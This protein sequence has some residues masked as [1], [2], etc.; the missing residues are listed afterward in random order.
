LLRPAVSSGR[1]P[2]VLCIHQHAGQYHLGKSEPAG[3]AG[4]P[5]QFYALELACRGFITL[6][7]DALCFE[8]RRD[9]RLPGRAFE[10]FEFTRRV[11]LGSNLQA[12]Y[13]WDHQRALDYLVSRDDV[14]ADRLGCIGHSLGGQ[15]TL[16]LTA[17]DDRIRAAVSSCGF[18]SL[19]TIFR[20]AINHNLAA[21]VPGLAAE[22]DLGDVLA[23]VSPRPF[24]VA[25]GRADRIFPIDGVEA[26][27][28][29]ARSAFARD[30]VADRLEFATDPGGHSFT[31]EFQAAGYAFLEKWLA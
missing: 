7:P 30:G 23:L 18:A 24:F 2:A 6:S 9:D 20:D 5:E 15:Q 10:T 12:K 11:S 1:R 22:A 14:D 4:N 28:D 21:Y 25:S 8:D 16:F 17:L 31:R 26:S 27:I 19:T 13:V 29:I 3:L